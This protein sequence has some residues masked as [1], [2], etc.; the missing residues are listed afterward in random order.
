MSPSPLSTRLSPE[1]QQS[2]YE[3]RASFLDLRERYTATESFIASSAAGS[4]DMDST[5]LISDT[6]GDITKTFIQW[7][8]GVTESVSYHISDINIS[9][10]L[11]TASPFEQADEE[12]I[13]QTI[14][15]LDPVI[16]LDF[17]EVDSIT[18]AE[19]VFVSVDRYRPWGRSNIVGQVVPLY[20]ADKWLVLVK[21]T[22]DGDF[23]LN[24]VI[25]EFGHSIGLSHPD[26]Q[27]YNPAY[28]TVQYTV[29]SYNDYNGQWGTVFTSND[30]EA[31]TQIWGPENDAVV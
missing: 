29:M 25:H 19:I 20:R 23:D 3:N 31:L 15:E 4:S 14:E 10:F 22:G 7:Q 1:S 24:T 21:D 8:P 30:L 13:E 6:F 17:V 12:F 18:G 5:I 16:D 9:S 2:L 27:P 28:N 26:E 11:I